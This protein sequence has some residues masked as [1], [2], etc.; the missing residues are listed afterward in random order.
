MPRKRLSGIPLQLFPRESPILSAC[1]GCGAL[2][3]SP[4]SAIVNAGCLWLFACPSCGFRFL[5]TVDDVGRI[6]DFIPVE[7]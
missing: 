6:V 1:P 3:T 5:L 4:T 2:A 7:E